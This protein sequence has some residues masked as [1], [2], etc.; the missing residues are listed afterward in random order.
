MCALNLSGYVWSQLK[1]HAK[2]VEPLKRAETVYKC[3]I[4]P[5]QGQEASGRPR[6]RARAA[7]DLCRVASG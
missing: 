2:A 7:L 3:Y 5:I 1:D 6:S 4:A